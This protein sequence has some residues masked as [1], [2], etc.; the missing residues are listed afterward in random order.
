MQPLRSLI[1]KSPT[2]NFEK[3]SCQKALKQKWRRET[4]MRCFLIHDCFVNSCMFTSSTWQALNSLNF[5]NEDE[6]NEADGVVDDKD[7]LSETQSEST[8]ISEKASKVRVELFRL[9]CI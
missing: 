4:Q 9:S 7:E 6:Y 1:L 5:E 3:N 2:V 8:R